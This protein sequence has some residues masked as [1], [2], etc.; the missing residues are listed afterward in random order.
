MVFG[1]GLLPHL[2][3]AVAEDVDSAGERLFLP[4]ADLVGWK[5]YICAISAAVA[6]P[7]IAST[8]TFAFRLGR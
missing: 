1:L 8:V 6:C 4:A 5:Q 7:L 2:F 3:A